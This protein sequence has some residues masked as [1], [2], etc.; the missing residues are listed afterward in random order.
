MQDMRAIPAGTFLMGSD[1]HYEEEAPVR[2][3]GV[4]GFMMD[5]Y[6][7]TNRQFNEFVHNTCYTTH[8]ERSLDPAL[9][10]GID[11]AHLQP[12]ALVFEPKRQPAHAPQPLR[13]WAYKSGAHWRCPEGEDTVLKTR[14][15]HPVTCVAYEDAAAYAEWAGKGLPTEAQW[16]YAARGG[17]AG[18]EYAW[19][20]EF[21]PGGRRMAN[22]WTGVFPH[23]NGVA[24]RKFFTTEVGSFPANGYGFYDMIGN[25]WE[26]TRDWY[27]RDRAAA[28][29]CGRP[30]PDSYDPALPVRIPRRVVKGGS[31]LCA[32]NYC[33]RYRPAARQPQMIDTASVHIG[34]RC[35]SVQT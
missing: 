18:A 32:P 31:F 11:P 10:R 29:C 19:G 16:E 30:P 22:T 20:D 24:G 4:A 26:W 5:V 15:D 14:L 2:Q 8:A 6:P 25:V 27:T 12:G 23:E 7:V 34:F 35:V 13:W 33:A 17:L 28:R 9:Y 1:R 21:A 3:V